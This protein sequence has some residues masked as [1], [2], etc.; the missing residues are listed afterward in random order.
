[1]ILGGVKVV[2][3]E[4]SEVDGRKMRKSA[5]CQLDIEHSCVKSD[6]LVSIR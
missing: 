6:T 5:E 2:C 1:M 4:G 3:L